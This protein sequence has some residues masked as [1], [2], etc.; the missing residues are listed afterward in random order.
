MYFSL[1]KKNHRLDS[2]T[3]SLKNLSLLNYLFTKLAGF[4]TPIF[5]ILKFQPNTITFLNFIICII[6]L[7][8]VFFFKNYYFLAILLYIIVFILDQVDGGISRLQN[9][10]TFFG[11]FLDSTIGFFYESLFYIGLAL[12]LYSKN[13]NFFLLNICLLCCLFYIFDIIILDKY[14]SLTRWC[15]QQNKKKNPPYIRGLYLK[16]LFLTFYDIYVSLIIVSAFFVD[17]LYFFTIIIVLAFLL[18]FLSGLINNILHI[19]YSYRYLN[20]RMKKSL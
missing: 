10:S 7:I 4:F 9:N 8:V 16:R 5:Y 6:S 2:K 3:K 12:F 15:N 19:F 17:N 1:L 18:M 11:K 13:M 14:S 20:F